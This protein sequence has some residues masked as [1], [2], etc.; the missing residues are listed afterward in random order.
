MIKRIVIDVDLL[1]W[2]LGR[3]NHKMDREMPFDNI[4]NLVEFKRN[5]YE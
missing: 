1:Y 5:V 2:P 3:S 4:Y